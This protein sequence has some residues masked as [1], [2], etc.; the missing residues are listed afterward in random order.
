MPDYPPTQA[1]AVKD[2]ENFPVGSHLLPKAGRVALWHTYRFARY[3]DEIADNPAYAPEDKHRWL[4][5]LDT[6]LTSGDT[7]DVPVSLHPF[8]TEVQTGRLSRIWPQKLLHAFHQDV[9][10]QRYSNWEE[11]EDYCRHSAVP[12]GRMVLE[13]CGE[14]EAH[15][16]AADKL[17]I[18]LQ[19]LNHAQDIKSDY[20]QRNRIY[21]PQTWLEA[22]A[23]NDF[24]QDR[25]T[26][27]L[28]QTL[29]RLLDECTKL[30]AH[31]ATLPSSIQSL[32]LRWE[33]A[34][35]L[36]LAHQ[37]LTRLRHGDPMATRIAVPKWQWPLWLLI[38]VRR[39][40]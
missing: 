29:D 27:A 39:M 34:F 40:R 8:Y 23:E 25:L 2:R 4:D 24:T 19:L 38:S 12:V 15:L 3:A 7:T 28:R 18:V 10:K 36:E 32:R 1:L 17:C 31:T 14:D 22:G 30:L 26:P 21:L 6:A 9:D 37:L 5:G 16:D 11:L 33:L 13:A 35:T 20:T